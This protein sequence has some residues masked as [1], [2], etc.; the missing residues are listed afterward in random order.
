MQGITIISTDS[1]RSVLDFDLRDILEVIGE[2]ADETEWALRD[3]ECMGGAAADDMHRASETGT[4]VKGT[5]LREMSRGVD[6]VIDGTFAGFHAGDQQP[7]VVIRAVDSTAFDV[8]C[9]NPQVIENLRARFRETR[10][11][12]EVTW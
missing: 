10:E 3:V 6:Q 4:R 11:I 12:S 7:W 1:A 8:I 5:R 2:I 9:D